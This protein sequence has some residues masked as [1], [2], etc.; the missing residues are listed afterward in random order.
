MTEAMFAVPVGTMTT[1]GIG[2]SGLEVDAL[3]DLVERQRDA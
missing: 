3:V 1:S 2:G